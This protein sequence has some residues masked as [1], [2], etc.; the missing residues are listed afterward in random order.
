MISRPRTLI[1]AAVLLLLVAALS[2]ATAAAQTAPPSQERAA[3]R[4]IT[5]TG[6]A[7][8]LV[9]PD[10]VILTLGVET[11]GKELS[12]AKRQNDEIV[13]KVLAAAQARGVAA[14]DLQ[15][16]H[17]SVEPRYRDSYEQRDFIGYFV[18][19]TIVVTLKDIAAFED[20]LSDVLDAG[21]S[22][23]HG[24]QFRTTEL[25]KHR[26]EARASAVRAAREKAVALAGEL[27]QEV[28]QPHDIREDQSEWWSWYNTWWGG[29]ASA[30]TQ[31]V[32]Q[33]GSSVPQGMEGTLAP[34]QISVTARVTVSFE[35]Q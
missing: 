14:K 29:R 26:D 24:I 34:G 6:E 23:V 16:D 27:G 4:L 2:G 32:V 15:T 31:N 10:E 18:R 30:M 19:K 17:I 1:I 20:L 33:E 3:P 22:N 13:A 12:L 28:G 21:A 11:S 25:R 7:E 5:T 35:M 9:V 8:V